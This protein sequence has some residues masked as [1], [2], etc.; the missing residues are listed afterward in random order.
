M[1]LRKRK[2]KVLV[3]SVLLVLCGVGYCIRASEYAVMGVIREEIVM[4][5]RHPLLITNQFSVYV[6]DSSWLIEVV[7]GA[8][9]GTT[10]KRSVWSTNG[11]DIYDVSGIAPPV[12]NPSVQSSNIVNSNKET[13]NNP[14][15]LARI[16]TNGAP[17]G[18]LDKDMVPH[19]WLM[20]ASGD[21]WRN[22]KTNWLVPV[23]DWHASAEMN[24]N[25]RLE[26]EWKLLEGAFQLPNKCQFSLFKL[27]PPYEH[28]PFQQH[29]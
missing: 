22:L 21:Y 3:C 1:I 7:E 23:Y 19:L 28:H 5:G 10:L 18:C 9:R 4:P 16:T 11:T 13:A 15:N 26:A 6:R 12:E 17:V 20:F 27:C 25:L 24:P 14:Y 8:D 29:Q 2:H